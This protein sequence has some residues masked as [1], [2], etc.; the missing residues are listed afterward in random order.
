VRL[1]GQERLRTLVT[2]LADDVGEVAVGCMFALL[3]CMQARAGPEVAEALVAEPGAIPRLLQMHAGAVSVR[4]G[5]GWG[6]TV[7][8]T[9]G[10]AAI[11]R[12]Q[13]AL[14]SSLSHPLPLVTPLHVTGTACS[15]TCGVCHISLISAG[16][17]LSGLAT[18]SAPAR[19][20]ILAVD[21]ALMLLVSA[22]V[23]RLGLLCFVLLKDKK[24]LGQ[25]V[26]HGP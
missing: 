21:G 22:A 25:V 5:G 9:L 15:T 3:I 11:V 26:R 10:L 24:L 14:M 1:G 6:G 2:A 18:D 16:T 12:L 8:M 7:G 4:G 23:L 19:R 17:L 13:V 20:A